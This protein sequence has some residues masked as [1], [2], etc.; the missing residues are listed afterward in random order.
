MY[1]VFQEIN[2]NSVEPPSPEAEGEYRI[3]IKFNDEHVPD[4]PF[5]VYISP[6]VGDAHLLEVAQFPEGSIQADKPSQFIVR[7]MEQKGI[8]MLSLKSQSLI[9]GPSGHEDDCFVQIIDMEEYSVRFMPRENGIHKIHAKFN[10][11]HI[12]GSPFSVKV[13]KDTADPAA[14]HAQGNG[15]KDVKTGVKTDF[16]VDTVNAGAGT[17][18][19]NID[20]PSKV[21]MDCT[22]VE[23]G[24]KVRYTPLAPGDYYAS[25]KYNNN[26]IVG[27]PFKVHSTGDAKVADIGGQES[28]SV[29]VETVA[30]VGKANNNKGPVLP[31][32]KRKQNQFTVSA[33]NAGVNILFVGIH[34]PKGPC[35]EVFIKH[36][37]HNQYAVNYLVR[38][39]EITW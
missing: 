33:Q 5:K 32:F 4:S 29:V 39:R 36:Q 23:E 28:S 3:G 8:S 6:A 22:E 37:G 12:P 34:G 17:L 27:S 35:E 2:L 38:E 19:V 10:G 15:L 30:K 16:I 26:H 21:S 18:A 20:G 7:E 14:V 24:Y 31:H 11:V 9:I 13:G 1:K 25:I